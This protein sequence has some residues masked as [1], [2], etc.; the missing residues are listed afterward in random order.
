M[1]PL[2]LFIVHIALP[3][4]ARSF[5]GASLSSMSWIVTGYAIV[6]ATLLVPAGRLA[7]H[8]G[9]R[10]VFLAGVAVFTVASVACA[11]A[12]ALWVAVAG[13]MLQGMGAAM[14]VPTSM[15]LLW[16]LFEQREH[17]RVV[18]TWAGVAAVAASMGSRFGWLLIGIDWRWIFLINVPLGLVT[19]FAGLVV[20]PEV[21]VPGTAGAVDSVSVL[22]LLLAVSLLTL[23]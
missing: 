10:R 13:R 4:I 1:A 14:M 3:S 20:V 6:F 5:S 16:P 8:F 7:D 12:P 15:G 23:V 11:C 18:G 19:F 2:D 17:N 21:R 22:T 9:R